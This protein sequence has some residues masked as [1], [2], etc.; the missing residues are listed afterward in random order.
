[1][2]DVGEQ[3]VYGNNGVYVVSDLSR[4]PVDKNDTRTFYILRPVY[5]APSNIVFTPVDNDRVTM[6]K[7]ISR[8]EALELIDRIPY[9]TVLEV[10]NERARREVYKD[11]LSRSDLDFYVKIIKTVYTRREEVEK[12]RRRISETDADYE[13]RAKYCLYSELAAV[14]ELELSSVEEFINQRLNNAV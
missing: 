5:D 11:A 2:F 6:R 14:F 1:M 7:I 13:R 3:I 12:K 10:E 8:E 9:I 4:S